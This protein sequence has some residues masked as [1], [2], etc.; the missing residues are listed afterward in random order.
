VLI[1]LRA[2]LLLQQFSM[3]PWNKRQPPSWVAEV[4]W[5]RTCLDACSTRDADSYKAKL[6]GEASS[7]HFAM[8]WKQFRAAMAFTQKVEKDFVVPGFSLIHTLP[9][10][11]G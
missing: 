6:P 8:L 4:P 5:S 3:H 11:D 1:G 2:F 7:T 10:F 9:T